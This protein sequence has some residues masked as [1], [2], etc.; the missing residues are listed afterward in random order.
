VEADGGDG[1][2]ELVND[3]PGPALVLGEVELVFEAERDSA[4]GSVESPRVDIA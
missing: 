1:I 2:G 3:G 4:V